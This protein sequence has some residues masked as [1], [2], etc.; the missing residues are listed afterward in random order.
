MKHVNKQIKLKNCVKMKGHTGSKKPSL[1]GNGVRRIG[2]S[3]WTSQEHGFESFQDG[4]GHWFVDILFVA[5][6]TFLALRRR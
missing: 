1:D 3:V 4:L 5:N 6:D 2:E